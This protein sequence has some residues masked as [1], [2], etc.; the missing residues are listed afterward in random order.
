MTTN[1]MF[2]EVF[3]EKNMLFI[4]RVCFLFISS[5]ILS[6]TVSRS[7]YSSNCV[8]IIYFL[9]AEM[10]QMAFLLSVW[11]RY[12]VPRSWFKPSGNVLVIF[13]EKGGDPTKIKFSRRK[14]SGV[15]ALVAEDYPSVESWLES[16]NDNKTKT[17]AYLKCPESTRISTIKFASFGT[18][19]GTCGSYSKG[20]CHD[21]NSTSVVEKV[22][23]YILPHISITLVLLMCHI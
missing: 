17:S 15:C 13:E 12:H 18:P 14:I 20:D 5:L 22:R 3:H 11:C 4:F 21:P 1:N 19:T 23:I 10:G 2:L 16:A 9:K 7:L 8:D 6:S